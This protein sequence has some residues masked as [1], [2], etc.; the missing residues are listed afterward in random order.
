[1]KKIL[2]ISGS[3]R[4]ESTCV[5]ILK[6]MAER[7]GHQADFRIYDKLASLPHFDPDAEDAGLPG[8]IKEFRAEVSAADAV[9]FCSPEYVFS[10][11]AILKNAIEW[12]VASTVFS[13]KPTAMIVASGGGQ[14]TFE[15]LGLILRTIQTKIT[16]ETSL[17]FSGARARMRGKPEITD[18]GDLEKLDRLTT[19]LLKEN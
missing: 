11:P 2:C 13:D 3:V 17:L 7:H 4:A 19:A 6:T 12:C 9:V 1:M 8:I 16:E 10:V 18:A 15:S 5:I 14:K